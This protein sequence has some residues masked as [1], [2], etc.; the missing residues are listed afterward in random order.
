MSFFR[1]FSVCVE[2]ERRAEMER[3]Q[4]TQGKEVRMRMR[5][6]DTSKSI[7]NLP[8]RLA[9]GEPCYILPRSPL[10]YVYYGV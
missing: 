3:R 1:L 6:G 8:A 4:V 9:R 10:S 7:C 5:D 2:R